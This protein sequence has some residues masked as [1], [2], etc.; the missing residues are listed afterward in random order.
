VRLIKQVRLEFRQ[1]TSDKVYEVDLCEV[2]AG[3][4]VVNF[5]YGRRGTALRD[6]SKTPAPVPQAKAEAIFNQLVTSKRNEGYVVSGAP[7]PAVPERPPHAAPPPTPTPQAPPAAGW[8]VRHVVLAYRLGGSDKIYEIELTEVRA[9]RFAVNFRHGRRGADLRDGTKTPNPVPRAVAEAIFNAL[10]DT[11][12]HEGYLDVTGDAPTAPTVVPADGEASPDARAQAVLNRLR[13]GYGGGSRPARGKGSWRLS[14]AIWRAGELG[15]RDAEPLLLELLAQTRERAQRRR[16]ARGGQFDRNEI[17]NVL[18]SRTVHLPPAG[19]RWQSAVWSD[20]FS[21]PEDLV[22]YV[23]AWS[24]GRC[25]SAASAPAL[26]DLR[27]EPWEPI[28]RIATAALLRLLEGPGRAALIEELTAQLPEPLAGLCRSGPAEAFA[29]ALQEYL[30][31]ADADP[32][33]V[34]DALYLIDN[35]HVRPALLDHLRAVPLRTYHFR[36]VRH[37]FKVAELRRDAEVHGIL[38]LRFE[39]GSDPG[40]GTRIAVRVTRLQGSQLSRDQRW[41]VPFKRETRR[42]LR[43]RAWRTL[44]RLGEVGDPDY[45]RLAVGVLL[46][47]TD[48][49]APR[50]QTGLPH[51]YDNGIGRYWAFNQILYRNSSRY[52]PM[53]RRAFFAPGRAYF[54]AARA[55]GEPAEREEAFPQLWEAAPEALLHLLEASRCE[56]V[57]RFAV[58]ALRACGVFCRQ[59]DVAALAWLLAAPYEVTA[60]LGLELAVQRYDRTRPNLDLVLALAHSG[61]ARARQQ[62]REWIDWQPNRFTQDLPFLAALAGSPQAETRAYARDLL[63]QT[64]FSEEAGQALVA[65]LIALLRTFT[66]EEGDRARDTAQTLQ[67]VFAAPLRRVGVEVIRDLAEHPLAEVRQFAGEL[68]LAH[69]TLAHRPPADLLL[70][71]LQDPAPAVRGVGVRL[72][73]QLPDEDLKQ[74]LDLLVGLSRHELADFRAN[75]RPVVKRLANADPA[76]G[77]RIAERLVEALL[78]PGAPEGVPSHTARLLREDLR[79]YLGGVG[80]ALVWKLLQSRSPPAQEVGGLLLA[81]NVRPEDLSLAEI[82]KLASHEILAVREAAW[83]MCRTSLDRLKK[84]VD[85]IPRLVD[86]KWEDSRQF[87]FGLLRDAFAPGELTP[88]V[89]VSLCD[90]VRPDVQQFGREMIT[91][92]FAEPDGPEYA[93]KLSEHP[94]AAMQMFAANF[95]ERFAG[96]DPARLRGLTWYFQSVLSRVNQG[97]VAKERVFA[98]LERAAQAGADSAAVVAEIL[99][100]QSATIAMRDRARAIEIL[101]RI[102]AAYPAVAMPLQVLPVEVRHGV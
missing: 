59:L 44:R 43:K 40:T 15:L 9:D 95:L 4:Y 20:T 68:L 74:N 93:L 72:F 1:G 60:E 25:G 30:A 77:R 34:L 47:F 62:A 26:Q 73:G 8:R 55:G 33:A 48:A 12:I 29:P 67:V 69:E 38:A 17:E 94:S 18:G 81:S 14:R 101:T 76:F 80:P 23:L 63:R 24:L 46:P 64:A 13:E 27:T 6:G 78:V 99:S 7:G 35:V 84:D 2:G 51:E 79:T 11:K 87:A 5:R 42:Y 66:A 22:L 41:I 31:R 85:T 90:S 19:N 89:L 96:T 71:L 83:Q 70:R 16:K 91:R 45:V 53:Q 50:P 10:V 88:Q 86:A 36:A 54:R 98:F 37:I 100:R 92:M 39:G 57:H 58:K 21:P 3:Q 97:R 52:Q 49:N 32:A 65:R 56:L 75:I 102:H 82:A 28:G 61:L